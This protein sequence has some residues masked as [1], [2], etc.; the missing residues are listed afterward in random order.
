M[1]EEQK[2]AS[3]DTKV[4][5]LCSPTP[6]Q[7]QIVFQKSTELQKLTY[8]PKKQAQLKAGVKREQEHGARFVFSQT[9]FSVTL[10]FF[11]K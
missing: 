1:S 3:S 6:R 7:K 8:I 2:K 11:R 10:C 4:L 9:A 5:V